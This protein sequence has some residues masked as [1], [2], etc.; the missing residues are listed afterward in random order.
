M[1]GRHIFAF[2]AAGFALSGG[3]ALAHEIATKP[4]QAATVESAAREPAAVVDAFHAALV[5][6]D[7]PTALGHLG[8][9]AIVF[10]AGGVERGKAEYAAHHA[11]ADAAFAKAVPSRIIRRTGQTSGDTAW[12]LSE[13]RTTGTY[14]GKHVDRVTT[15]TMLLRRTG[16]VWRIIHVHW[17][18]AASRPG[19]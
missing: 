18:S 6:G 3:P 9:D 13:E 12:I 1:I 15:E 5:A 7:V 16:G 17:S 10:E 11:E 8:D 2:A 4:N 14:K 19:A